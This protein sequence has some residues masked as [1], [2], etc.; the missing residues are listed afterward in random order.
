M[1]C[2]SPSDYKE[3]EIN[4]VCPECGEPTVDGEAFENCDY[5]PEVCKTCGYSPCDLSC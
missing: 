5:S 3:N 1:S 4:G 2:C